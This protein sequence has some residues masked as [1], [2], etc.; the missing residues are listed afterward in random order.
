MLFK[1]RHEETTGQRLR[2]MLWPRRSLSRSFAYFTKRVLRL[3]ATPHAIAIGV[4]AGV[5]ISFLPIPGLHLVIAAVAAWLLSGNV[6][7]SAIS[8]TAVGN[9]LTF[10]AI[11]GAT[12]EVGHLILTGA[13]LGHNAHPHIGAMFREL[14]LAELRA[15]V[16]PMVVGAIPL[17]LAFAAAFYFLTRTMVA[18]FQERRRARLA[19]RAAKSGSGQRTALSP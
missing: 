8:T 19:D 6:V 13:S 9:P 15:L 18:S 1:R 14:D 3:N 12:Y 10:P 5:F 2:V 17:G 11:W 16:E 4:A 7:A